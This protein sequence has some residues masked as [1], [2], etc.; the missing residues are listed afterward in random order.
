MKTGIFGAGLF[1][2]LVWC[3]IF[4]EKNY[5]QKSTDFFGMTG[6]FISAVW[7]FSSFVDIG[8]FLAV[9]VLSCFGSGSIFFAQI[10]LKNTSPWDT[11]SA[12]MKA[13]M[14]RAGLS[15]Q[16][17]DSL[18][19]VTGY[20]S[21]LISTLISVTLFVLAILAAFDVYVDGFSRSALTFRRTVAC[22]FIFASA[23]LTL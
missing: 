10:L 19:S 14:N 9:T 4:Y 5:V 12:G 23:V 8:R 7:Y 15:S 16:C 18:S 1:L 20:F 17:A 2:G 3:L 22:F 13:A 11:I 6:V 21:F